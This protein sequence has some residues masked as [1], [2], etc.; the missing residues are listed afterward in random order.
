MILEGESGA[1]S[2]RHHQQ[3]NGNNPMKSMKFRNVIGRFLA[4]AL[5]ALLLGPVV[6]GPAIASAQ[7]T[8]DQV[9]DDGVDGGEDGGDGGDGGD[10]DG[11]D[12]GPLGADNA[13]GVEIDANGVLSLRTIPQNIHQLNRQRAAAAKASLN[14]DLAT[15]SKM[16][17]VS[18]NRLEAE[19]KKLKEAGQKIPDDMHLSLI[20]I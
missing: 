19:I 5:A 17:K 8:E 15:P 20:H 12:G 6:L 3:G 16:R 1:I 2:A 14:R 9:P 11:G 18:L 4:I 13:G 10:G 7:L